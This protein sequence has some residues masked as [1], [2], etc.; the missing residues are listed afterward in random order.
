MRILRQIWSVLKKAG[1][2]FIEDNGMKLSASLS[3]YTL[4]SLGPILIIII[5]LAGVY[6]G[7][8]AVEGRIYDEINGLVGNAAALQIQDI[9]KN[10][11]K[12]RL[13]ASGAVIGFIVLLVGATGV[14][15]EIQDSINYIWSIRSKPKKGLLKLLINRLI[16]FSLIVSVGFLLMVSLILNALL[17]LL[18]DRLAIYFNDVSVYLFQGLNFML[19]YVVIACLFAIIFKVLPDASIRWRD[20]FVGAA[21]T[22]V[23][24]LIGK[25]LI[26][27]YV[28][29]SSI[30][31]TYG[32]A[33]SI[34]ILLLWIYYTSIILYYGAEFTK[35]YTVNYGGGIKPDKTAVFIIKQETR[36]VPG[37]QRI[38]VLH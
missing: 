21:F 30:G 24:F 26:S 14:F 32:T 31:V 29:N 1:T 28:T 38:N 19:I 10:I 37:D 33:A 7:R 18:H 16:S 22:A 27:V 25:S 5:S 36:E 6:W 4:F 12:S 34:V 15:T 3:Y 20:A 9:I 13:G 11:E 35:V 2:E 8:D 17:D 23:L